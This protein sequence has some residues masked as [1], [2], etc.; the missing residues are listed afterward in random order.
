MSL[1]PFSARKSAIYFTANKPRLRTHM[2]KWHSPLYYRINNSI[3]YDGS[4]GSQSSFIFS[5]SSCIFFTVQ[6][7]FSTVQF[8]F[9]SPVLLFYSPVL[10]LHSPVLIFNLVTSSLYWDATAIR[11]LTCCES[12]LLAGILT[13]PV[14]LTWFTKWRDAFA[15]IYAMYKS[16]WRIRWRLSGAYITI[17]QTRLQ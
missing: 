4:G 8:F 12:W 2:G 9:Y 6:F 15:N 14:C 10:F 5:Q 17:F 3:L 1:G 11:M 7:N 13:L 16:K